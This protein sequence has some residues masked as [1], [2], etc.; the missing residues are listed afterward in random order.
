MPEDA[1]TNPPIKTAAELLTEQYLLP[2]P[3]DESPPVVRGGPEPEGDSTPPPASVPRN[4][5]GT[6]AKHRHAAHTLQM[7]RDMGLSEEEIDQAPPEELG[8]VVYHLNRQ[9]LTGAMQRAQMADLERGKP[10]AE[11][12]SP[13]AE[14]PADDLGLNEAEYDPGLLK[15]IK[16]Q[17]AKIKEME[18]A[19]KEVKTFQQD[20]VR[21]SVE[22]RW[23]RALQ[24]HE[25]IVGKGPSR[26][27]SRDSPEII[28]RR[29]VWQ[30]VEGMAQKPG[31]V[32][33]KIDR[34]VQ[35]LFGSSPPASEPSQESREQQ[36]WREGGLALPTHRQPLAEG[37]GVGA[38]RKAVAAYMK[39]NSLANGTQDADFLV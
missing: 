38:A 21:E 20:R 3:A 7:A 22:S 28:K 36:L 4:P 29:A 33:E 11:P 13:A 37:Q 27:L 18:A 15:V 30:M 35:A 26:N 9:A 39:E 6:F 16:Q 12:A 2:E 25:A 5:D 23:D 32:E 19:L 34:A 10:K 8:R 17:Q 24:K 14:P 1:T 31:T